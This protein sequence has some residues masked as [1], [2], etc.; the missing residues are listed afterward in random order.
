MDQSCQVSDT[1][2]LIALLVLI[3][4]R[5]G[6]SVGATPEIVQSAE[7]IIIEVNTLIP[8]LEGLHDI[9][10]SFIPPHRQ[11]YV[12]LHRS[13]LY[14]DNE[15]INLSSLSRTRPTVSELRLF[16]WTQS[17][18][19]PSLRAGSPITRV[20]TPR[21]SVYQDISYRRILTRGL[22]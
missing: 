18:L 16:P 5:Q 13:F 21:R 19:S 9:N 22:E 1:P 8:N 14:H 7:K 20:A 10:Q 15:N 11:P 2:H 4:N 3:P 17:V 6:A 12:S